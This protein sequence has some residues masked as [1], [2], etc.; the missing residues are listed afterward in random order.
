MSWSLESRKR[1][2]SEPADGA[3]KAAFSKSKAGELGFLP[4][5]A[6]SFRHFWVAPS[7][8]QGAALQFAPPSVDHSRFR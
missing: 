2:C 8:I 1:I 3:W 5:K 7:Q 4:V 6:R